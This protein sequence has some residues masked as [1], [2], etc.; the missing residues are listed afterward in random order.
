[1]IP[2]LFKRRNFSI[3]LPFATIR[4]VAEY[5]FP[6]HFF[7]SYSRGADTWQ[8]SIA[9]PDNN[10]IVGHLRDAVIRRFPSDATISL[11]LFSCPTRP[12]S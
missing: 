3:L 8:A 5:S 4:F 6:A 1:M 10:A 11:A 2:D 9:S 12:G 7:Q